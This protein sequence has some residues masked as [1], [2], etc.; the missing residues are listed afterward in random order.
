MSNQSV[1]MIGQQTGEIIVRNVSIFE[2]LVRGHVILY[3]LELSTFW[4]SLICLAQC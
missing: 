2:R 3:E 4:Y 1:V